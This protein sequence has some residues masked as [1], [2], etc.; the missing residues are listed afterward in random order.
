MLNCAAHSAEFVDLVL[1]AA[2]SAEASWLICI[3]WKAYF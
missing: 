2:A 1:T 3:T